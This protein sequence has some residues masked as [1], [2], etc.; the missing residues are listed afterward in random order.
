[1]PVTL[2]CEYC[3]AEM[4][5]S[6]SLVRPRNFCSHACRNRVCCTGPQNGRWKG[7]S[8]LERGYRMIKTPNGERQEH[9]VIMET[10]LGRPLLRSEEVHHING[11]KDDNRPE[12][13]QLMRNRSEHMTHHLLAKPTGWVRLRRGCLD[14]GLTDRPHYGLGFC[15]RCYQR[16]KHRHLRKSKQSSA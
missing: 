9:R 5:R 16:Q 11:I 6:P 2:H 12:N 8:W 15:T 4:R 13:L 14:C 7:G 1:M 10:I 3:G